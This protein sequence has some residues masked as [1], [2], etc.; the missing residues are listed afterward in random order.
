MA[1][2]HSVSKR[3]RIAIPLTAS[4]FLIEFIGGIWSGSLALLSDSL[5]VLFDA[6]A[7]ILSYIAIVMAARPAT[8][9][10]SYGLHRMEILAALINGLVLFATSG[11]ILYES[12]ERF[13]N[14]QGIHTAGML[15]IAAVGFAVNLAVTFL[16]HQ[17]HHHDL[18][19]RS[20]YLHVLGDTLASAAVIIGGIVMHY[21][22]WYAIDPVLGFAIGI[23][24]V[25][26]SGRLVY[27]SL[28]IL[29]E[30]VPRGMTVEEVVEAVKALPGVGDF[31]RVHIWSLCSHI[32]ALSAHIIIDGSQ[33]VSV[34]KALESVNSLLQERYHITHTTLQSEC[35]NCSSEGHLVTPLHPGESHRGHVH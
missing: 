6:T 35:L 27:E 28:H 24:L 5:H 14:P 23:L 1:H 9:R 21:T 26:G 13:L 18:N 30:G 34:E 10:H 8:D 31:H 2:C 3:L 25:W 29:M 4:I 15:L 19:V 12:V 32:R 16:L 22:G 7:L 11:W 33:D 17:H 20:A